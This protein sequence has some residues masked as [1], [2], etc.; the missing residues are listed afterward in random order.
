MLDIN[1]WNISILRHKKKLL[2][3]L[4]VSVEK[5][6]EREE[7]F[8]S[9]IDFNADSNLNEYFLYNVT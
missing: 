1:G 5:D 8:V 3:N 2:S 7:I 4:N 6:D 9:V